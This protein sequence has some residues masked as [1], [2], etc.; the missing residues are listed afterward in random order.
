MSNNI[1]IRFK[2]GRFTIGFFRFG[3]IRIIEQAE[4]DDI[5][6][7]INKATHMVEQYP[8]LENLPTRQLSPIV[9]DLKKKV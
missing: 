2:N 4:S 9:Y 8:V 6:S 5:V 1:V 7:T 3:E